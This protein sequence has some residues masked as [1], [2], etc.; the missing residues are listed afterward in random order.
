MKWRV[1]KLKGSGA[2]VRY[3]DRLQYVGVNP[4]NIKISGKRIYYLHHEF[5]LASTTTD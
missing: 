4:I 1:M 3:L 2:R 5:I